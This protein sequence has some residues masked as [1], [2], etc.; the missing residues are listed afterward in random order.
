MTQVS[1]RE[2]FGFSFRRLWRILTSSEVVLV[3]HWV[4]GRHS[5][6]RVPKLKSGHHSH[7]TQVEAVDIVRQMA[8]SYKDEEIALT[9]NRL[10]LKTGVGNSWSENTSAF[11]SIASEP[12][13][14]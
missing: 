6:L 10:R 3:I 5:E 8:G 13:S 12:A 11:S 7:C 1:S 9:L 14:L 2:L 4:G